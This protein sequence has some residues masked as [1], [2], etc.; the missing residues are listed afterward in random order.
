M[1][2]TIAYD[3]AALAPTTLVPSV[4]LPGG[5]QYALAPELASLAPLFGAGRM[6]ALLNVG[7]LVQPTTKAQYTAKW[8]A[9]AGFRLTDRGGTGQGTGQARYR[10]VGR[11]GTTSFP[12]LTPALSRVSGEGQT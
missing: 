5:R 3:L 8:R 1:R 7:T 9:D 6:A 11:A 12:D 4:A 10:R 2:P